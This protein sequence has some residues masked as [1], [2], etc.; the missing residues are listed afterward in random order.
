M[1]GTRVS[2]EDLEYAV[3]QLVEVAVRALSPGINDPNTAITVLDRLGASLCD[4]APRFLPTGVHR[5]DG[6]TVLVVPAIDYAGLVDSMFH[7]IRQNAAHSP[8]VLIRL[9]EVL[10]AVAARERRPER[11]E[12]LRRHAALV[13]AD[14]EHGLASASDLDDVRRRRAAF[15]RTAA[16]LTP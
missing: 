6:R 8:A 4:V 7:L 1:G 10:T 12:A 2:D 14:A 9:L 15:E 3:R 13:M 16:A 11:I 5:R